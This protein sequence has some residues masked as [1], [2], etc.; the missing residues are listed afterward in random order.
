MLDAIGAGSIEELFAQIPASH[1]LRAELDLPPALTSEVEL[2]RHLRD[3]LGRNESCED[4]L[5]FLGA[6]CWQHHVPAVC[7]EVVRRSEFV[8]PVWGT[9]ASDYGRNQAWFEFCSQLGELLALDFVGLPV[10]SWGCGAGHAVRMATRINGRREVLVP[11]SLDPERLAVIRT[12]CEPREMESHLDLVLVDFDPGQRTAGSGRSGTE[13]LRP[14]GGGLLR[15]PLVPR[16]DRVRRRGDRP[17][18]A[19]RGRGGDRRRRPDLSRRSRAARRLG[20][21]HRGRHDPAARRAHELRRRRRRLHRLARRG[22]LRAP[23]P[24]AQYLALRHR[25]ARRARLRRRAVPPDLLRPARGGQR[26]D[27]QLDL[28][29]G[30]RG[31]DVHVAARPA[32][33]RGGR[34]V[35]P[36]AQPLRRLAARRGA[37]R[38]RP[39]AGRVLQGVRRVLRR[40]HGRG[41]EPPAPRAPDLRRQGPLAR[42]PGARAERAL[43]RDRGA[44]RRATSSDSRTR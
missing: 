25:R 11:A 43:L 7:D 8:T 44:Q 6:G 9:P 14:H 24:D 23:V 26:L 41:G 20:R 10:Y 5:S 1:R 12:Y 36:A 4:N 40:R 35:D 31:R 29:V 15:E 18:R 33:V 38:D 17:A 13:A 34:L 21:R 27:G 22:A 28:P 16:D 3:L 32:R 37:G 2:S 19:R 42:L 30:D 39:L